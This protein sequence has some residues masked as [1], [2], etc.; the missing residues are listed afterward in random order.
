MKKGHSLRSGLF[1]FWKGLFQSDGGD[2]IRLDP[3]R[4][5]CV[6]AKTMHAASA[7]CSLQA[8]KR[9]AALAQAGFRFSGLQ[10]GYP[11]PT[12]EGLWAWRLI[13]FVDRPAITAQYQRF[14]TT[15]RS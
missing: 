4:V 11:T 3:S 5:D 13:S 15:C 12:G 2:L 6:V 8:E 10:G 1:V 7:A 14:L 9:M